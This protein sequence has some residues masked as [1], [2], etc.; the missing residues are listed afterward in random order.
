M[1]SA[2][3]LGLIAVVWALSGAAATA[4]GAPAAYYPSLGYGQTP[5]V[6]DVGPPDASV[7]E[8]AFYNSPDDRGPPGGHVGEPAHGGYGAGRDDQDY[9]P[10]EHYGHG[11]HQT[12]QGRDGHGASGSSSDSSQSY[13]AYTSRSEQEYGYD[14]GWRS[15]ESERGSRHDADEGR[16]Y[17]SATVDQYDYDS[18]WRVRGEEHGGAPDCRYE[19]DQRA[20][21]EHSA[22]PPV[23]SR[24]IRLPD[25][26]FADAGGVGP[27]FIEGGGGGGGFVAVGSGASASAFASASASARVSVGVRVGVH[28]HGHGGHGGMPHGCGCG[29]G[30]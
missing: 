2:P 29:H 26:F 10:P 22:C 3:K 25:S 4:G 12:D 6:Y 24:D 11:R 9:P 8:P 16:T 23:A 21:R 7:G 30:H 28:G 14:S 5:P 20:D 27:D 15:Q 1:A 18:G 17:G 13:G 19:H